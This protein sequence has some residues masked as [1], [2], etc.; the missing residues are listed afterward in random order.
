MTDCPNFSEK[1]S[2]SK[3]AHTLHILHMHIE[4]GFESMNHVLRI[5]CNCAIICNR[6]RW[7]CTSSRNELRNSK[8]R[9]DCEWKTHL[10]ALCVYVW[11][12]LDCHD[13]LSINCGYLSMTWFMKVPYMSIWLIWDI[14]IE[15]LMLVRH[16]DFG[17]VMIL[18]T[19]VYKCCICLTWLKRKGNWLVV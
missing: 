5:I 13:S 2:M 12:L 14:A 18:N 11:W 9:H 16:H 10:Y 4:K 8:F 19:L 3:L 7:W 17:N 15:M 1:S 6:W